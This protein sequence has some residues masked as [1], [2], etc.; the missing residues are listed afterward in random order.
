MPSTATYPITRNPKALP[1]TI[2][3]TGLTQEE[4][5]L[6]RQHLRT[7]L[8]PGSG[9][10]DGY[11]IVMRNKAQFLEWFQALIIEIG[12]IYWPPGRSEG[13]SWPVDRAALVPLLSFYV[14]CSFQLSPGGRVVL[15]L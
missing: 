3:S 6:L 4:Y 7:I 10:S 14:F 2:A 1:K 13:L 12:P 8:V 5:D 15:T 11:G 9:D